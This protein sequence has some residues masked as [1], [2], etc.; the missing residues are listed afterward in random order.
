MNCSILLALFTL[1]SIEIS[2]VVSYKILGI[3]PTAAP[4]HYIVGRALMQGLAAD[5]NEVTYISPFKDENPPPNYNEIH[6]DGIY[7]L[8]VNSKL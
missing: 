8:F 4:S 6:L 3:F 5:G 1:I 2:G 7:E